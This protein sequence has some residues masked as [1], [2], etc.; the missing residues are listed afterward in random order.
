MVV[1]LNNDDW[2]F[3]KKGYSFMPELERKEVIESLSCVDRVVVMS[4]SSE[5]DDMSVNNELLNINPHIFVN[6]GDRNK[7]N[8]PEIAVCDKLRCK[9]VFN[10]GDGG[11]VQSSSW[12]LS[13]YLKKFSN[14][15]G[16]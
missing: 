11:K 8:I 16:G 12:L 15:S 7:K 1:I 2:L 3:R 6:G 4:H 5:S 9:M 10:I 14:S 13:K